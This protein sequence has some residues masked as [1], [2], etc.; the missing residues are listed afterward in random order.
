MLI[1]SAQT[2][3]PLLLSPRNERLF[4][5]EDALTEAMTLPDTHFALLLAI[6][7][8]MSTADEDAA[9]VEQWN[10]ALLERICDRAEEASGMQDL[11]DVLN[12]RRAALSVPFRAPVLGGILADLGRVVSAGG[13]S[14]CSFGSRGG[15]EDV[16]V[17]GGGGGGSSSSA[18]ALPSL[19]ALFPHH[20]M[21]GCH[22][23]AAA[24]QQ[25]SETLAASLLRA[26]VR[27]KS[28]LHATAPPVM[29]SDLVDAPS[30]L[31][32]D[33]LGRAIETLVRHGAAVSGALGE[34]LCRL[35]LARGWTRIASVLVSAGAPPPFWAAPGWAGPDLRLPAM[36][37]AMDDA[38]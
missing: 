32:A 14:G 25:A 16:S 34:R 21:Y 15:T 27:A 9:A 4:S 20:P 11:G 3:D 38:W 29:P 8:A 22:A 6:V 31:C 17:G 28:V 24:L 19:H 7:P 18:A 13:G 33:V 36:V 10:T 23:A 35:V 2:L 1:E 12:P 30:W 5:Y 26:G 37:V